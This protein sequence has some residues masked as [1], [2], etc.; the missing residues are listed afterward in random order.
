[1][2]TVA[3]IA[4]WLDQQAPLALS[5]AWDNTGL[6]LGDLHATVSSVQTCLTLTASSVR[7]A[8][9]RRVEMVISHH[10]LPFKPISR[11]TTETETGKLL[12]R[13]ATAKISVYCPHTAWDSAQFGINALIARRLDLQS[14]EP[15]IP[16]KLDGLEH[17]GTGR[18][19]NLMRPIPL[20]QFCKLIGDRLPNCRMRGVDSGKLVSR[21]AIA[22]G[23]GGSL[24]T[25]AITRGCELFL[26]GE[27]TFH[28]CLEA[29]AA[30][31]SMLLIGHFASEQFAMV[32][33]AN[34]IS[35]AFPTVDCRSSLAEKDPVVDF[36]AAEGF[37]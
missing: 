30:Q 14:I 36:S 32:E 11:L 10:P 34:S 19:G 28:A 5:E 37:A 4:K 6:L 9:E 33:L 29:E 3:D 24:L 1:M 16:G 23:S 18:I 7:E 12:W 15:I 17:L 31:I 22:C 20:A 26:T 21:V 27:A 25:N 35:S 2:T 13:L 8:L